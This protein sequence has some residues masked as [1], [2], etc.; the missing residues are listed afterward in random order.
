MPTSGHFIFIPAVLI[1]GVF[2]GFLL[3]TR[4]AAD[5]ANLEKRREEERAKA[6]AARQERKQRQKERASSEDEEDSPGAETSAS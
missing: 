2:I 1:I 3:G 4:A 5:R 6:R